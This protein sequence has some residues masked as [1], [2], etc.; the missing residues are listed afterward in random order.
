MKGHWFS[1]GR[2]E[3]LVLLMV[4][5]LVAAGFL[6]ALLPGGKTSSAVSSAADSFSITDTPI[7]RGSDMPHKL[8][9]TVRLRDTL[10]TNEHYA[11]P[12]AH[13]RHKPKE[14]LPKGVT[15]DLNTADS[16]LLLRVPGIGPAFA[17]RILK[18]RSRLGGFYT[19][20]Q[21]QEVYGMDYDRFLAL[22]PY[23]R[24]VTPPA[25]YPLHSLEAESLPEHPYLSWS[26]RD[27][28][29]KWLRREGKIDSWSTLMRLEVFTGEDSIRL[30]PY[31][32]E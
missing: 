19:V 9:A 26:Q 20:M 28:L 25:T 1:I 4:A 24:I 13:L 18:L 6:M 15:L 16:L 29:K 3:R 23:F 30:S 14:T 5:I 11:G 12:P 17:R 27:A 22:R 21:L 2:G 32:P 7:L 8:S 10:L 31:F